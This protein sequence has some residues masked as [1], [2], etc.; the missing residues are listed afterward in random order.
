[1]KTDVAIIVLLDNAY[2]AESKELTY[3]FG[4]DAMRL[5]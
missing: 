1:M 4:G 2:E 3:V 5:V